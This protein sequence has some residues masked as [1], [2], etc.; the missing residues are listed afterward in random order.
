MLYFLVIFLCKK[1]LID[2][3]SIKITNKKSF[4]SKLLASTLFDEF[5]V[6][7]AEITTFNTFHIDGQIRKEFF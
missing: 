6:E 3:T 1:E 2:M 4:M 5:L 7:E